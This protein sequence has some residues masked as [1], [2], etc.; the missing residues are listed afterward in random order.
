[1][2]PALSIGSMIA[3]ATIALPTLPAAAQ[4]PTSDAAG[5]A[6]R[7]V[8]MPFGATL[9]ADVP[10]SANPG[11]KAP[12]PAGRDRQEFRVYKVELAEGDRLR[13]VSDDG[14][15]RGWIAAAEAIP[16]ERAVAHFTARIEANPSDAT[17]YVNRAAVWTVLG[18]LDRA[19]LDDT[20]AVRI[21]RDNALAY[22]NRGYT[23]AKKKD[24]DR[25]IADFTRAILID[26]QYARAYNKRGFAWLQK[27]MYARAL[28]DFTRAVEIDPMFARAYHNRGNTMLRQKDYDKAIADYTQAIRFDRGDVLAL[29]DR[30]SAEHGKGDD[31]GA[32]ADLAEAIRRRPDGPEALIARAWLLATSP[33][34]KLRDAKQAVLDATRACKLTRGKEAYPLGALAAALAER[35]DFDQAVKYQER[36]QALYKSR[37]DVADGRARLDLYKAKVPYHEPPASSLARPE[38]KPVSPS[39][40]GSAPARPDRPAPGGRGV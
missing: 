20:E 33:S 38:G 23:W 39:A 36:A 12:D 31:A 16:I 18:D 8:V 15:A 40:M 6:G 25:A 4:A 26:P 28:A 3:I 11:A 21:D 17:N 13:V 5:W 29:V 30:A 34:A 22:H 24:L 37:D 35:G 10:T 1:M 14:N 2:R 9:K 32:L 27:S 7:R 19:L